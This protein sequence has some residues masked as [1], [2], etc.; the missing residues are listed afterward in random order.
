MSGHEDVSDVSCGDFET[1]QHTDTQACL[2]G[3]ASW[4]HFYSPDWY[5]TLGSLELI[6]AALQ[7]YIDIVSII[8]P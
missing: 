3:Y 4:G 2:V 6:F 7:L 5:L 8:L 1:L